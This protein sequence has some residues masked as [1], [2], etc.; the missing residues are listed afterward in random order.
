[1]RPVIKGYARNPAPGALDDVRTLMN[2]RT[3]AHD[4][5]ESVDV[6]AE[7]AASADSWSTEFSTALPVPAHRQVPALRRLRDHLRANL[8]QPHPRELDR[9][10]ERHPVVPYVD[11]T[12]GLVRHRGRNADDAA[13]A[14][15]AIIVDAVADAQWRRLRLCP[16]CERAFYDRSPNL[17]RVWCGMYASGPDG[18][19]CGTIAKVAAYRGRGRIETS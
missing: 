8:G 15:L 1:M 17:S 9:W 10:L 2:T 13:A 6:L 16:G 18:R 7:L 5:R 12:T 14:I 11:D 3:V 19:A 4:T